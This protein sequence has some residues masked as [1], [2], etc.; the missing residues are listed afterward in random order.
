MC[1]GWRETD[2]HYHSGE[3]L[4]MFN[5]ITQ[6]WT[7]RMTTGE[8]PP[9]LTGAAAAV[10]D[11]FMYV[12]AGWTCSEYKEDIWALNLKTFVWSK[13]SPE[14][15][16]P[17]KC[18]DTAAWSHG[19]KI[20]M[21]GGCGDPPSANQ[22]TELG[23]CGGRYV[24]LHGGKRGFSNQLVCY[25]TA[26]NAWEWPTSSGTSPSPRDGHSV[27][28]VDDTIYVFGGRQGNCYVNDFYSLDLN[29]LR[30]EN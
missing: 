12:V 26:T 8:V 23:L 2:N 4:I 24:P 19:D 13:L 6:R 16:P 14:G 10:L 27:A 17:L 3:E 30:F 20:W 21:F 22:E 9:G 25:N 1:G 7:T 5:R 15:V 18:Y 11:H 28:K 29:T